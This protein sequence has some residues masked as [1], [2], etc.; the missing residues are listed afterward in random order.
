M[1]AL[2]SSA[3]RKTLK[4]FSHALAAANISSGSRTMQLQLLMVYI[5]CC[6]WGEDVF[7]RPAVMKAPLCQPA[8][9]DRI[10]PGLLI[11]VK[12]G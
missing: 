10:A 6:W 9:H 7:M 4:I 2:T 12:G 3:E 5:I 8:L 11:N 1:I